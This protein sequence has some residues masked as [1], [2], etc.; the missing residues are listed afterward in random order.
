M[1]EQ[2]VNTLCKLYP[3]MSPKFEE[4]EN[5]LY[6]VAQNIYNSYISRF[7]KKN[8]VTVAGEEFNVI[9]ECHSFHEQDRKKNRISLAKVIEI[10]N[11][12]T[13]TNLNKMIRRFQTE[14]DLTVQVSPPDI[15]KVNKSFNSVK[16]RPSVS[17]SSTRQESV[18]EKN[19]TV[20]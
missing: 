19:Y 8:W 11:K 14:K 15:R 7:I 9:R 10:L 20:Q 17:H 16:P 1:Q 18:S 12:Q 2:M 4:Y 6:A 3:N 5:I 13:P